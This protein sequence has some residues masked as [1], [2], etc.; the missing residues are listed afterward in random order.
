MVSPIICTLVVILLLPTLLW[1]LCPLG[2]PAVATPAPSH[3]LTDRVQAAPMRARPV[4]PTTVYTA[5]PSDTPAVTQLPQVSTGFEHTC[6]VNSAGRLSC[7]GANS[8]G[9]ATV[10]ADLG[11][12]SHVSAGWFHT[13]AVTRAATLRCWGVNYDGQTTIP[14]DPLA[15]APPEPAILLPLIRR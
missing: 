5:Q 3:R 2:T 1:A 4:L 10:P 14:S 8:S 12:V 6:V 11:T 15:S 13:C 7:W 9:E